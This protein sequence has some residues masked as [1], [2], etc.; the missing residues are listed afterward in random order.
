M[1][2]AIISKIFKLWKLHIQCTCTEIMPNNKSGGYDS[3]QEYL[4]VRLI[5]GFI[6]EIRFIRKNMQLPP[7][8]YAL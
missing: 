5:M 7:T 2:F 4:G 8:L 1:H 3:D 6:R